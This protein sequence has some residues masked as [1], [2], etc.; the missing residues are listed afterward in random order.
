MQ[1]Q[2]T[3]RQRKIAIALALL[4]AL[5]LIA[6]AIDITTIRISPDPSAFKIQTYGAFPG[7][8]VHV[9]LDGGWSAVRTSDPAVVTALGDN[10]FVAG[11]PGTATLSA[12]SVRCPQCLIA[13]VLWR[14]TVKVGIPGT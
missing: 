8:R 14:A 1:Q 13:T 11:A 3:T 2:R 7:E 9:E 5:G 6:F 12:V 10:W 4:V